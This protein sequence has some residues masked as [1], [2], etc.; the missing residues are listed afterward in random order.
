M[1]KYTFLRK[2][3]FASTLLIMVGCSEEV[4]YELGEIVAPSNLQISANIVGQ[5]TDNPNGDGS[6]I[7][8]YIARAENAIGYKFYA[9][10]VET[11]VPG[12][13][14]EISFSKTG[15]NDYRVSVAAIGTGGTISS[16]S[17]ETK[18]LVLYS[19]PPELL[20]KLHGDTSKTW[21][22]KAESGGH[23]GLG[24][25]GG[26]N[27]PEWYAA[28]ANEKS[29]TG[30]YDDRYIFS[31]DGTFEHQT[32]GTVF[33][34]AG[35]ID[36]LGSSGGTQ[37]GDD[38]LNLPLVDYSGQWTISAPGGKE[39]LTLSGTGFIGY[40]IGGNHQ[41]KIENRANP[42]ELTIRSTDGN[43]A[44]DWWFIITSE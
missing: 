3:F 24:P 1:K 12:G 26:V 37:D 8:H 41:Y 13:E 39:T 10:N 27:G 11:L 4:N 29:T 18:V 35:L 9:N 38:I 15:L 16:A 22:I 23:F 34:R 40:Y 28:G 17:L 21:R 36:E 19:P 2:I 44:L 32:S 43:G 7:V 30:M 5:D 33:G 14:T 31:A 25:V 6:G 42:N 20:D